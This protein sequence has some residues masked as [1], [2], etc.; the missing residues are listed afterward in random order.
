MDDLIASAVAQNFRD[1]AGT[2]AGDP[3]RFVGRIG[4]QAPP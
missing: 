2:T 3:Y 4:A 1:V